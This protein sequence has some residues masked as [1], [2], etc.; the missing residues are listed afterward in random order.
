MDKAYLE[1]IGV[2][3]AIIGGGSLGLMWTARLKKA[4]LDPLLIVRSEEQK[5]ELLQHGL[6]YIESGVQ[7]NLYP[8]VQS[9]HSH[10][11]VLPKCVI[12]AVKQTHMQSLLPFLE[13]HKNAHGYVCT[14]QNGLGHEELLSTIFNKAQIVLGTTS[15]GAYRHSNTTVERTGYGHVWLGQQD[16][17]KPPQ[18]V[19]ELIE[20]L[21]TDFSIVWDRKILQ[22]LWRKC[23]I[24]CAINPLTAVLEIENG[25]LPQCNH[26]LTIMRMIYE[27]CIKVASYNKFQFN[28]D[29]WQEIQDV[30]RNTSRNRSSMLQD[31]LRGNKTEI[32]FIN[33]YIVLR[34]KAAG[35]NAPYNEMIVN[36][37]LA[38]EQLSQ[39]PS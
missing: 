24:N 5:N 12:L 30:C 34:A 37:V 20:R 10:T 18:L 7:Q 25:A 17:E 32:A 28:E 29:L 4:N 19:N 15:D 22:R 9:I 3:I 26:T 2:D 14:L 27:E 1:G 36:L 11:G 31:I 8:R 21:G 16:T 35:I 6:S 33:G 23:V 13:Q 39:H 38:K